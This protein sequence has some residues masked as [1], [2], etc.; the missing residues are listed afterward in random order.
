MIEFCLPHMQGDRQAARAYLESF[1]PTL[2][3]WKNWNMDW[4]PFLL[5]DGQLFCCLFAPSTVFPAPVRYT[6]GCPGGRNGGMTLARHASMD[7][8]VALNLM[9]TWAMLRCTALLCHCHAGRGRI[10]AG[11]LAG[12]LAA[13]VML[14][15]GLSTVVLMVVRLAVAGGI[16]LLAFG[17]Q[18]RRMFARLTLTFFLVSVLFAGGMVALVAL[19]APP[20]LAGQ[21]RHRLFPCFGCLA[22][23]CRRRR[24][25][26]CKAFFLAV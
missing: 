21:K 9:L 2:K 7:V 24:L 8:L 13:L 3:R 23:G 12:G 10:A 6:G 20:G 14:L 4:L 25:C 26:G 17:R 5:K 22:D 16:V 15:P 19:A 11:S 1:L 18:P